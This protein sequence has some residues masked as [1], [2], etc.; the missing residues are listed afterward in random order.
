MFKTVTAIHGQVL[1]GM[2]TFGRK[3]EDLILSRARELRAAV[4]SEVQQLKY[5]Y[6]QK[7][8]TNIITAW[9]HHDKGVGYETL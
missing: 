7:W 9:T 4:V 5:I 6:K 8:T 2:T 3:L 1:V